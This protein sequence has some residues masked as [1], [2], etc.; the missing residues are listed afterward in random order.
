[1]LINYTSSS[2]TDGA[3]TKTKINKYYGPGTIIRPNFALVDSEE[4]HKLHKYPKQDGFN[5][6]EFDKAINPAGMFTL[7]TNEQ[8]E[9]RD[10]VSVKLDEI[11][12]NIY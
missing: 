12:T 10:F 11:S 3:E 9:I 5:F 8:I 7:G 2:T 4:Y 1:L 6:S